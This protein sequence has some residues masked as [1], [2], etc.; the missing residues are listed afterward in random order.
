MQ[1]DFNHLFIK[2]I[3]PVMYRLDKRVPAAN[4]TQNKYRNNDGFSVTPDSGIPFHSE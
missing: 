4:Y 3:G 1:M 2:G